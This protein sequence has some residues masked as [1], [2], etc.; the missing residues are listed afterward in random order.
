M[1]TPGPSRA[2]PISF[3]AEAEGAEGPR[4][5]LWIPEP[6]RVS[7][8]EA[9]TSGGAQ[10]TKTDGCKKS[11]PSDVDLLRRLGKAVELQATTYEG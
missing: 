6:E 10:E 4:N 2:P 3:G 7:S 1:K 5:L 9:W 11:L 8:G